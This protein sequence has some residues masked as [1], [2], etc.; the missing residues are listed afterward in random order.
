V[1]LLSDWSDEDPDDIYARLKKMSHYYN[2]R[3]RTAS[4]LWR[5]IRENGLS[6]TWNDRSMWNDMRMSDRDISD[7]TGYTY[8][9]LMNGNTPTDNWTGM[10]KKGERLLL[11]FI[12]ASAMTLFDVRIPGLL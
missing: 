11:R 2:T 8:T 4:D 6:Q 3:E 5:E 7:V 1:I 10:F 12:N 9:Y